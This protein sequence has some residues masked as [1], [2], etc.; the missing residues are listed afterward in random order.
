VVEPRPGAMPHHTYT[1]YVERQDGAYRPGTCQA[2]FDRVR[3]Q[4]R[5]TFTS[6]SRASGEHAGGGSRDGAGLVWFV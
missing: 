2:Q 6:T 1:G 5:T 3:P 4:Q